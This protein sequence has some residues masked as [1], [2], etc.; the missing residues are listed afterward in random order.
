[1]AVKGSFSKTSR[2]TFGV[3]AVYNN[4]DDPTVVYTVES[5]FSVVAIQRDTQEDVT[6]DVINSGLQSFSGNTV[7][8]W[9]QA[10]ISGEY[11]DISVVALMASGEKLEQQLEMLVTDEQSVG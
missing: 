7:V 2:E 1:M 4:A 11:Y 9:P 10:G 6:A 5:I 8:I 3:A